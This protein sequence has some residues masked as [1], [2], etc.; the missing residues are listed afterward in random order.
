[1][2]NND[3]HNQNV[4]WDGSSYSTTNYRVEDAPQ[5]SSSPTPPK[6]KK[7]RKGAAK[8][9]AL[10]LCCAL[11]GGGAGIG[12]AAIY[13]YVSSSNGGTTT[14]LEGTVPSTTVNVQNTQPGEPMSLSEI[15]A[16]YANSCVVITCNVPY[17]TETWFGPSSGTATSAGSGFVISDNGYIVTNYHVI[18]GAESITVTF[19]DG[20]EYEA[21]YVGGEESNDV[22]VLKIDA[23]GLTPV[24]LGD[25]DLL[26]VGD[27][28]S[29]IGNALGTLSFSQTSGHVSGLAR[30]VTYSDG[31]IINMLQTD[32][33][34]NSGNSG[35]PLFNQYGQVV[36]ITSAKYSGSSSSSGAS[37]E[38]IG[39]A[40][41]IND[42]KT[43]ITEIMEH[44]YVTRPSMGIT[45]AT[46]TQEFSQYFNWPLGAYVNSV[47]EGSC[48]ETAGLRQGDII[49]ALGD[50]E[51]TT[52]N[53]LIAAKNTYS[54]GDTAELT[55]YRAGET[56]TLTITFDAE[57]QDTAASDPAPETTSSQQGGYGGNGN[58]GSGNNGYYF[59]FGF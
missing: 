27:E 35:G 43:I 28:V 1:M 26:S 33:T 2:Y 13:D 41:P 20:S 45:V 9:V 11:L 57:Q 10:V 15:Y 3:L 39:F 23:T 19:Y 21:S 7:P 56:L 49:T 58:S 46:V 44:G 40:I 16:A 32:C 29:T 36:G 47:E 24:V 5:G 54:P 55:V 12:G 38:N 25:S 42:V 53:E 59:P 52:A 51:V 18:D 30:S 37:I 14:V 17:T 22:A 6:Q 50:T 48:A 31:T 8:A 34:I 4:Q